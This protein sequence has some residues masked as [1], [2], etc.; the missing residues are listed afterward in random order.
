L[1]M[2]RRWLSCVHDS[3]GILLHSDVVIICHLRGW[4]C[5]QPGTLGSLGSVSCGI[6][7]WPRFIITCI[8]C[9]T[10]SIRY[11]WWRWNG[12]LVT[13]IAPRPWVNCISISFPSSR[14][15]FVPCCSLFVIV[16][17]SFVV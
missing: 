11:A 9:T 12:T 7:Q 17:G 8:R 10:T 14:S 13:V 16:A 2:H 6:S 15:R 3:S 5:S 1:S 4:E